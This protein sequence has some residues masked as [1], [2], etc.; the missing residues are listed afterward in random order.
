MRRLILATFCLTLAACRWESPGLVETPAETGPAQTLPKEV[1]WARNAAE[2]RAVILQIYRLATERV[3]ALARDREPG[4]WAV[5]VDA[6]ETAIDNSLF[7]VEIWQMGSYNEETWHNWVIRQEATAQ[8]GAIAFLERVHELGGKVVVVTNRREKHCG[9]T[10]A[11][12]MRHGIPYDAML[13][14][15]GE[16]RDKSP[17]WEKVEQGTASANLPPLE[18]LVW[19]GDNIIDFPGGGQALR[20]EPEEAFQGFGD[21]FFILPNPM[22]G[23]WEDN[24]QD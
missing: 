4:T 16:E 10:E 11:V 17:R 5:S 24:P 18:I 13:C 7:E 20:Y 19:V 22:Y 2:H 8:P 9:D 6:D 15:E 23:S 14:R 12:F 3:E 21:R 1:H